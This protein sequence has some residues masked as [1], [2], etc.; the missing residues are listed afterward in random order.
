MGLLEG[1]CVVVVG[2]CDG[3]LLGEPDGVWDGLADGWELVGLREGEELGVADGLLIGAA[4][5]LPEGVADGLWVG[6][7]LVG[8]AEG[9]CDGLWLGCPVG[10]TDGAWV[11]GRHTHRRGLAAVSQVS[12]P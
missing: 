8:M 6:W 11:T 4:E 2:W 5:G 9:C 3:V 12:V 7:E 10:D 1:L